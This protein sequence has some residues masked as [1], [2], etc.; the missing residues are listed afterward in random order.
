ML[1]SFRPISASTTQADGG[2]D[3]VLTVERGGMAVIRGCQHVPYSRPPA[4][5]YYLHN[6]TRLSDTRQYLSRSNKNLKTLKKGE[7]VTSIKKRL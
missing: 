7:N 5:I 6:G 4:D 3:G 1:G 2:G